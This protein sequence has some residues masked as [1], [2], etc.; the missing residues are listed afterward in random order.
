MGQQN[1]PDDD[2]TGDLETFWAN[3]FSGEAS[4]I[5]AAWAGLTPAERAAVVALLARIQADPERLAEQRTAAA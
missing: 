4:R 5:R 1:H 3:I 2:T